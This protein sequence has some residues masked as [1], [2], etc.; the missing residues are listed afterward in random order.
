MVPYL[1]SRVF[2]VFN[3]HGPVFLIYAR[4]LD[5]AH[6]AY[7][8]AAQDCE[9]EKVCVG[10]L[11]HAVTLPFFQHQDDSFQFIAYW[12]A[13]ALLGFSHQFQVV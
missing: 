11:G 12:T 5:L 9:V 7:P 8:H 10:D 6:F 2:T 4:P 1:F 3:Q 13:L